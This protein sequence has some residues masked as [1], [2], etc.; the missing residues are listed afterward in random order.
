MKSFILLILFFLQS[1]NKDNLVKTYS[2]PKQK[3]ISHETEKN[4]YDL[5]L[6]FYWDAPNHWEEGKK[7]SMRIASY[8]VPY[9][10]GLADLSISNF[11]GDGGGVLANIN[12]WRGQLNLPFQS[13]DEANQSAQIGL[14][15]IGEFK[16]YKIIND[17][18]VDMA[19]MCSI[20]QVKHSTIFIKIV[21]TIDGIQELENEFMDFCSSFK[22]SN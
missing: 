2:I 17:S 13:L 22:F 7:S 16:M 15:N 18:N 5:K 19:F 8:N 4:K 10:Q 20:L 9:S 3:I 14:S 21:S 11:S 1:C 12:R 6:P